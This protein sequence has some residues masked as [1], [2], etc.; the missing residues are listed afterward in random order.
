MRMFQCEDIIISR[1][2][3]TPKYFGYN[4]NSFLDL[5]PNDYRFLNYS[6]GLDGISIYSINNF[7]HNKHTRYFQIL[8]S[9]KFLWFQYKDKLLN[10]HRFNNWA[11]K[12]I[13]GKDDKHFSAKILEKYCLNG[14]MHNIKGPALIQLN[15]STFEYNYKY[16][17]YGRQYTL[18]EFCEIISKRL[19]NT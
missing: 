17:I 14:I 12:C 15:E 13:K 18:N 19:N 2:N 9:K 5:I 6:N 11:F 16:Y 4:E 3:Y 8:I 7:E 1:Y 10:N